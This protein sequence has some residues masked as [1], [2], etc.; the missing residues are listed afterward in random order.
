VL[1]FTVSGYINLSVTEWASA[2]SA[3]K[4]LRAHRL[5]LEVFI[6]D[7]T[8]AL[9]TSSANRMKF[10][11]GGLLIVAAVIYQSQRPIFHDHR[12]AGC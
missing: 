8:A 3:G 10:I 1:F 4:F 12:R 7:Q 6:M 9:E 5:I 11:I 2:A